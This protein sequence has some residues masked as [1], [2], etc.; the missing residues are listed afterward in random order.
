MRNEGHL[1]IFS[2]GLVDEL[3]L[4]IVGFDLK[5]NITYWNKHAEESTGYS[6]EEAVSRG[7]TALL[8]EFLPSTSRPAS[9]SETRK[10]FE[11]IISGRVSISDREMSLLSGD[12]CVRHIK[13]NS[14]VMSRSGKG[15]PEGLL[16]TGID[17][18]DWYILQD[19]VREREKYIRTAT[20]RLKKYISQDPH[21]SL[22]NYRHFM[23]ELHKEFN[24][25]VE[26]KVPLAVLVLGLDNFNS[27]NRSYGNSGGNRVLRELAE[28]IKNSLEKN[29]IASRFGGTEFAV[30]LPGTDIKKAHIWGSDLYSLVTEH[31]FLAESGKT[32]ITLSAYMAIGGYPYCEDVVSADQLIGRVTD[33]IEEA[34]TKGSKGAIIC[35]SSVLSSRRIS[36]GIKD[37]E[38][39][40]YTVEFVDAL[41]RAVK[42][43]DCYTQEHSS[44]MSEYAVR[45]AE[46]IGMKK[47]A[48]RDVMFGSMLHDVGKI[49]VDKFILL[50]PGALTEGEYS[51]IKQHP[52]IGAEIIR[53]VRPLK[54]VVPLVLYHHERYDGH[55]YLNGLK[56]EEIPLGARIISLA[57]VFQ[58]LTSDRPYRKAL[59][60]DEALSIIGE[61]SGKYF[62]PNIVEAFLEVYY[63]FFRSKD[64]RP[65]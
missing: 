41:A 39:Y 56:G 62:D 22:L 5:G 57:D 24:R 8:T 29:F 38:G 3:P 40:K 9:I 25:S 48:V 6:R 34:K 30:L 55:G 44:S 7:M 49:G 28:I 4:V 52:R 17:M 59:P 63:L 43:K 1:E 60:E 18:T 61:Y 23:L 16:L 19:T 53:N 54:D 12:G 51:L 58:A 14:H 32:G 13:W 10:Y 2:S 21:T 11:L 64:I 50:K 27:V 45:L 26:E 46:H 15:G 35:P 47:S 36:P 37:S 31:G 65:E 42:S 20:R 33:R